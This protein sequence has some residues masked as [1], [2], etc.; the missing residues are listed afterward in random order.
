MAKPLRDHRSWQEPNR[1][2]LDRVIV[3][4]RTA[5]AHQK[6][7]GS[8]KG[9]PKRRC[10]TITKTKGG[11]R[12]RVESKG[13]LTIIIGGSYFTKATPIN[14]SPLKTPWSSAPPPHQEEGPSRM[15]RGK[16]SNVQLAMIMKRGEE[17][18]SCSKRCEE[19][20]ATIRQRS[21]RIMNSYQRKAKHQAVN[22]S[23]K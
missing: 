17:M 16:G 12:K 9:K 2:G 23:W 20:E 15:A 6:V 1:L 19:Q 13:K 8:G 14:N 11:K 4:R 10:C 5:E 7:V 21:R 3:K 18:Q 22:Q